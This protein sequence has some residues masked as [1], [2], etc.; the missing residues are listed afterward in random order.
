VDPNRIRW[1]RHHFG[2]SGSASV[3]WLSGSVPVLISTKR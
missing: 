1:D 2:G 3:A